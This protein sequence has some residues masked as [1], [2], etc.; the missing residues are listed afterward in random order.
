LKQGL[1]V[2]FAVAAMA[3]PASAAAAPSC[4]NAPQPRVIYSGYGSLESVIVDSQ[5][6]LYFSDSNNDRIMRADSPASTPQ[7]FATGI[8]AP[9]GMDFDPAT[10]DLLVGYG[11]SIPSGLTGALNPQAGVYRVNTTTGAKT[12]YVNGMQMANGVAVGPS[13]EIF[14]SNDVVSGIDRAAPGG[15]VAQVRWANVNS[16][17]GLVVDSAGQ[18]L[19]AAQTFQ[20]P[21]IARV[22][23][24]DPSQVTTFF[25]GGLG[26]IFAG[27]DGLT[28]DEHDQLYVAA[29]LGGEVWKVTNPGAEYCA[30]AKGVNRPSSLYFGQGATGFAQQNL[31]VVTFGGDV[32]ELP[33]ARAA[34]P[35]ASTAPANSVKA[36]RKCKKRHG[37]HKAK[38]KRCKPKKKRR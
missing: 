17:N 23:I 33:G 34:S 14:G 19:Y 8:D 11:A 32:I 7:P 3:V 5:G 9:G 26:D 29:N 35:A 10:G 30:L 25:S 2:L 28:R 1:G 36:K 13:G 15:G 4:E 6:R 38:R 22:R 16:G 12:T 18:Y 20:P 37:R 21:A 31:Y 24:S 27:L